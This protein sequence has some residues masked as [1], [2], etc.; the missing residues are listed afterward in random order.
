MRERINHVERKRTQGEVPVGLV[1]QLGCPDVVEMAGMANFDYAWIDCEHGSFDIETAVQMFRA[2]DA[3][4]ITP[5]LRV[6]NHERSFI[7]RALDA[8]AMGIIVP[9]VETREQAEAVVAAAKYRSEGNSGMRG[10]CPGTRAAWHQAR[11]WPNFVRWSNQNTSVWL[12]VESPLGVKNFEEIA[13]VPGVDAIVMGSFDLAQAMGFDGDITQGDVQREV[14]RV[15][16][17]A[18]KHGVDLVANMFA[19][20]PQQLADDGARWVEAGA[21]ILCVGSDRRMFVHALASR[22][23]AITERRLSQSPKRAAVLIETIRSDS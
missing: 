4:G 1:V 17:L 22:A 12:I 2:A 6:P 11:D 13:Q 23:E 20:S 3:V 5:L 16:E 10:A 15:V 7:M 9:N 14:S 18:A 21:A 19:I 8:G